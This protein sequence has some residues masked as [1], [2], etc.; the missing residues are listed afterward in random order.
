MA[1]GDWISSVVGHRRPHRR[2]QEIKWSFS[3]HWTVRIIT[4]VTG[5]GSLNASRRFGSPIG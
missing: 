2:D 1:L 5:F 3:R 4:H